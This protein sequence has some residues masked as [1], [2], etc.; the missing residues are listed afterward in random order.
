MVQVTVHLRPEAARTL[1]GERPAGVGAWGVLEAVGDLGVDLR[2]IHPG[3]ADPELST[4]F[5]VEVPDQS[6][7]QRIVDRLS[8][9]PVVTAAYIKPEAEAP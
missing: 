2:P 7:A 5:M 6:T 1:Q 4:H 9:S 8:D 3:I